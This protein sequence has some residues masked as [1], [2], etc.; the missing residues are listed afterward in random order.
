MSACKNAIIAKTYREEWPVFARSIRQRELAF[1]AR[2]QCLI[3]GGSWR[4]LVP[5]P[6]REMPGIALDE[7]QFVYTDLA[8]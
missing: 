1:H 6:E 5:L 8:W 2:D 3:M 4:G 7:R